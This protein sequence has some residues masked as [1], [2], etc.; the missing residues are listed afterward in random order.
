MADCLAPGG[1]VRESVVKLHEIVRPWDGQ[2]FSVLPHSTPDLPEDARY[3]WF[4]NGI[5]T[6][7]LKTEEEGGNY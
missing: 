6:V 3:T 5:L 4:E 2:M 7:S 1:W